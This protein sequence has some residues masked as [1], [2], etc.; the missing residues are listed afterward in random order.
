MKHL[1]LENTGV[2]AIEPGEQLDHYRIDSVGHRGRAATTYRA[3]DLNT[4]QH[5]AIEIPHPQIE[6]DPVFLERYQREEEIDKSLHHPGL[7]RLIEKHGGEKGQTHSYLVREWFEGKS[8]RELLSKGKLPPERA[9]RITIAVCEI[10]EYIHSHGIVLRD[11]E[12]DH[13]LVGEDDQVKL[14]H[15]G[16]TS[17]LG[18]RRL[19]FT[20][21]SQV[22]GFSQYISPEELKGRT[23]DERSD[24]YSIGV[25]LYEMLTGSLPFQ[26]A[27]IEERL[28]AY[29]VPPCVIDPGISPQLQEVVY[30]ALERDP[31]NRYATAHEFA[32]DLTHLDQVGVADRPEVRDW[33][34]R[35]GTDPR[36]VALYVL[37][38]VIPIVIFGLLLL[39][40]RR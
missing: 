27:R 24:I 11:L 32:Q 16:I 33:K 23:P 31:Q 25:M 13:I 2:A 34:K 15:I 36:K 35:Q 39:V 14:I 38:V 1:D 6:A 26:D 4:N 7:I 9:I 12:P 10:V 21:L 28:S 40:A 18:A 3:T 30:R 37:L 29:P 19:T 17:K 8:L 5:V 22:V 20:K